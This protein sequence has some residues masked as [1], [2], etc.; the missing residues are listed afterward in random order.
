MRVRIVQRYSVENRPIPQGQDLVKIMLKECQQL[1]ELH[2]KFQVPSVKAPLSAAGLHAA[3]HDAAQGLP[4]VKKEWG[5]SDYP[6][7][8][9]KHSNATDRN[10]QRHS[11]RRYQE[12][13]YERSQAR[14]QRSNYVLYAAN[15]TMCH[16]QKIVCILRARTH[17]LTAL[18]LPGIE[19]ELIF[20]QPRLP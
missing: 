19:P 3:P 10:D 13:K 16:W 18:D 14:S 2:N 11:D 9:Q 17:I 7:R 6:S 15:L 4:S 8:A 12:P 1:R 5:G 20:R